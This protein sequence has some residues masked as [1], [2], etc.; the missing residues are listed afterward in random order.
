MEYTVNGFIDN[1]TKLE[2]GTREEKELAN[3]YIIGF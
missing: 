3:K 1:Y 2:R